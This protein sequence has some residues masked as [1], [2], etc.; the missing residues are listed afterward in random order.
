M[1]AFR[2]D[3]VVKVFKGVWFL[4]LIATLATF[5]YV[6]ASLPEDIL[7]KEGE[8]APSITRNGLFYLTLAV[9]AIFNAFVF[10]ISRIYYQ[11]NGVFKAWFYGLVVFLNLFFIVTLQF[12]NL[13][14]SGEKFDY[15]SIG[16]IIYGSIGLV[17]LW[18][19]L[20][21]VYFLVQK[22]FSKETI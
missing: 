13:Y 1:S 5:M 9:I 21:P 2:H 4:S 11:E 8:K 7:L 6:Y 16:Y 12:L 15:E 14:N 19:S 17:V 3:M 10:V 20:W 18:S 22:F